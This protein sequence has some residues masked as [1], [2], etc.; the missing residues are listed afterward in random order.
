MTEQCTGC[1]ACELACSF[2]HHKVFAPTRSRIHI[3]KDE[4]TGAIGI[5]VRR[6]SGDKHLPCDC[7]P[8][9]RFCIRYCAAKARDELKAV[10]E[11]K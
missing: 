5:A 6:K 9:D 1:R 11:G 10:L 3:V 7:P 4:K 8:N 2:H